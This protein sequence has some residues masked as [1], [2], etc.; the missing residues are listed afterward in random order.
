MMYKMKQVK[1]LAVV[2]VLLVCANLFVWFGLQTQS[3]TVAEVESIAVTDI[4]VTDLAAVLIANEQMSLGVIHQE[5]TL[6]VLADDAGA[7]DS[8]QLWAMISLMCN[9][10]SDKVYTDAT[11]FAAY[12]LD[13]PT[14]EVALILADGTEYDFQLLN[15]SGVD[16]SYYL[17]DV[18]TETVYLIGEVLGQ[19]MSSGYS[20]YYSKT[21]FPVVDT[22]N[23]QDI[24]EISMVFGEDSDQN[25]TITQNGG[26]FYL[27]EPITQQIST[28]QL[29]S[30]LVSYISALYA[31]E[32]VESDA[33]L[34]A[35]GFDT[36][37]LQI[38]MTMGGVT[39]VG[40]MLA[41]DDGSV[42]LADLSTNTVYLVQDAN[43]G[44]L[45]ADYLGLMAGK[46]FSIAMG[47]LS[48]LEMATDTDTLTI[49]VQG[50]DSTVELTI[51]GVA[52]E[53]ESMVA[54][55]DA[56][57]SVTLASQVQ[58]PATGTPALTMTAT[59]ANGTQTIYDFTANQSGG[60][61]VTING[62]TNFATTEESVQVLLDLVAQY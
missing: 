15:Q 38:S 32:V 16:G 33:D 5:G 17:Y 50:L 43:Y 51:G 21:V 13:T 34:S 8:T 10:S 24:T 14:A 59:Y 7:F 18:Q 27:T 3:A 9:I 41:Q 31:E 26:V 62:V 37:D 30:Q 48:R 36:P 52:L 19:M 56:V 23:Y 44:M 54:I 11:T 53:Q 42:L 12:G 47:D 1:I 25:Y 35:Y 55:V 29:L 45:S 58:Q 2:A 6:Q 4:A 22:S 60:F 20:Y 40:A 61:D 49:D 46:C 28:V 57:N 39:Y